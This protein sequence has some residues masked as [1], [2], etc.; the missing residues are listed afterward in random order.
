MCSQLRSKILQTQLQKKLAFYGTDL[1]V[2][3]AP[4]MRGIAFQIEIQCYR[5]SFFRVALEVNKDRIITG[6][7]SASRES[8]FEIS[9][10]GRGMEFHKQLSIKS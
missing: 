9:V 8:A 5:L 7:F 4:V 1:R 10:V 3:T 2:S 6:S